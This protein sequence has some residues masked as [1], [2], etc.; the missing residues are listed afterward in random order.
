MTETFLKG[1]ACMLNIAVCDDED[2]WLEHT[3]NL[4]NAYFQSHAEV[5]ARV[6]TFSSA[7]NL[8]STVSMNGGFDLYILDVVMPE[9]TGIEAGI[10]L[11]QRDQK[12]LIIFLTSSK[13]FALDSYAVAALNYLIKPVDPQ[14]LFSTL[15]KAVQ[16]L[17]KRRN[18]AISVKTRDGIERI[19]FDDIV[20]TEL[21]GRSCCYYL[22]NGRTVQGNQ[23]RASF[24]DQMLPLLKDNRFCRC[25]ASFVLN[26]YYVKTV[27][28]D[29]VSLVDGR[30]I[31]SLPK[32]ACSA[33][34]TAWL[35]YWFD[36]GNEQ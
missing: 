30:G 20:Y 24:T 27:G 14:L 5:S 15:D 12:G 1:G 16:K 18:K 23:Q 28:K 22:N 21:I 11:R 32:A 29:S 31:I 35:D 8:I 7:K 2:L 26:L 13:D 6:Q 36:G 17:V 25:G 4:V 33:V 10:Q 19:A 34:R 9:I 3:A